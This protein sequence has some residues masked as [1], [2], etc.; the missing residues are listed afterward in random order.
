M[1]APKPLRAKRAKGL[2]PTPAPPRQ[3]SDLAQRIFEPK[4]PRATK[5]P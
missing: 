1:R 3:A 5:A 2:K 4:G